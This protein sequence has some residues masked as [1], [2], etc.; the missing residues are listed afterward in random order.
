[1]QLGSDTTQSSEWYCDPQLGCLTHTAAWH[2]A[3]HRPF[4]SKP[5]PRDQ[6]ITK[7]S[8]HTREERN[9]V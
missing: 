2:D 8:L 7:F 5:W 1:M 3:T 6:I 9:T 4:Y